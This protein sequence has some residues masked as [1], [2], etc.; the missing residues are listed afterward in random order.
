VMAAY[1]PTQ[2]RVI[3]FGGDVLGDLWA[4]DPAAGGDGAWVPYTT[5]TH[6]SGRNLGLMRLDTTRNRLLLF[7]G[8]G[9]QAQ[10]DNT[11]LITWL[12]DT[13][14]LDL[15][16]PP[17]WKELAPAGFTPS[18]RDRANGAYDPLQDRLMLTCGG[19][20]GSN[21]TWALAFGDRPTP[22]LLA[23][24]RR[25]VTTDRVRL[26]WWGA[27]PGERVTAYRRVRFGAWASLAELFA[28]GRGFVTLE[29]RDV[30]P[31]ARLEYRL[32]VNGRSGESFYGTTAVDVPLRALSVAAHAADGRFTLTVELPTGEPASLVLYDLAGRRVW[33]RSV[34]QLGP[35]THE[36]TADGA[37]FPSALYFVR[38]TQGKAACEARVAMTR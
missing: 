12:N 32:G 14:A 23:L 4:L 28:D 3:V 2:D 34:G 11:L 8:Y 19:I 26:E 21:D 15:S 35:G 5:P 24:A 33:S 17:T 29:D 38:L 13:W 6:P 31:G 16:G 20:D 22:T 27:D 37:G 30:T 9:V 1:D 25:D 10:S 36:L 18:A 7:G